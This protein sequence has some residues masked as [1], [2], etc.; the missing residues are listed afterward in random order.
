MSLI[1]F[2]P[3]QDGV[4]GVNAAATN[5]PLNTIYNDY[6]GNITDA[7][8]SASAAIAFNK[9]A[10]GSSTALGISQSWTPA[11]TNLT[12]GNGTL[13]GKSIQIGKVVH[14]RFDLIWGSTT[15]IT[16]SPVSFTLPSTS[17]TYAGTATVQPLGQGSYFDH[18]GGN[19]AQGPVMWASTGTANLQIY[20]TDST[21]GFNAVLSATVSKTW[22]T[23]DEFAV[24]GFYE[25]A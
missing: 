17:V 23:N 12:I 13:V 10:G 6:N 11:F 4:T 21:Y 19:V 5:N 22:T 7:N 20:R 14:F 25:A 16:G 8:I 1:T 9:I 24:N 2:T 18:A 15:S 3:L